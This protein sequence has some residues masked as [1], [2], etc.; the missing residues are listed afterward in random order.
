MGPRGGKREKGESF[1]FR[2]SRWHER[3]RTNTSTSEVKIVMPVSKVEVFTKNR[4][5]TPEAE[6][7][8][9]STRKR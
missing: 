7:K 6:G 5:E 8:E 4:A 9:L 1:L 3:T 2:R